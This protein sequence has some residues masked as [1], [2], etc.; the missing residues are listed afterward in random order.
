MVVKDLSFSG[1]YK[2]TAVSAVYEY[3]PFADAA[4]AVPEPMTAMGTMVA[5][6]MGLLWKKRRTKR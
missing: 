2:A 3:E 4:A 5:A 6:G 1:T